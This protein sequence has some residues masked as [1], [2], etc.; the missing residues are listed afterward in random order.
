M[1]NYRHSKIIDYLFA[2]YNNGKDTKPF[3]AMAI[4]EN[5]RNKEFSINFAR[6]GYHQHYLKQ[7]TGTSNDPLCRICNLPFATTKECIDHIFT[8][9]RTLIECEYP[10]LIGGQL[11][12]HKW[13]I[14]TNRHECQ[15]M[16]IEECG[17]LIW[18]F[19][20]LDAVFQLGTNITPN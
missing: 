12:H 7:F 20:H 18:N 11:I 19:E 5:T 4:M 6:V 10:I 14:K 17:Q 9:H 2:Q 3:L 13:N 1:N 15:T 16:K 8:F